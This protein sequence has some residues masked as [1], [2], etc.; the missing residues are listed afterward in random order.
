MNEEI[1]KEVIRSFKGFDKDLRCRDFQ[2]EIGK[3]Y[4]MEGPVKACDRGFHACE[5]PLDALRYYPP[6]ESRYCEVE[7][8]GDMNRDGCDTKVASSKITVGAE[9]GVPGLIKAHIEYVKTICKDAPADTAS[10]ERGNAAASGVM[11]NAAASGWSG[12]AAASGWSGNA[13]ASGWSGNAAA[14]GWSGNAAAS[15][16]R[17]N[18]AASGWSG[19]AAASG[20]RGVACVSGPYGRANAAGD[21]TIAVAWGKDSRACGKI[22]SWIV[23]AEYNDDGEIIAA[24]LAPVDGETIKADTWYTLKGGEFVEAE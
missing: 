15:G 8:A 19:N 3:E 2:Y 14:S 21:Q 17:G 20:E 24:K 13:A 11:G 9:I 7:Q 23:C 4:E 12:N 16:W 5:A 10:G 1:T 18:A 6:G 22:G